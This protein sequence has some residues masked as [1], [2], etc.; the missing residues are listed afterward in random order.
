M[1]GVKRRLANLKDF[2][3]GGT[4]KTNLRRRRRRRRSTQ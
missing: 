2:A 3:L 4:K 1:Y